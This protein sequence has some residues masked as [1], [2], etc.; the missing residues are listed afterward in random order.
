MQA[1]GPVIVLCLV[2]LYLEFNSPAVGADYQANVYNRLQM[3]EAENRSLSRSQTQLQSQLIQLQSIQ[4][5]LPWPAW[6]KDRSGQV[7]Y[8]NPAY[9]SW[10]LKPRGYTL[11]DYVGKDD[12]AVWPEDVA[13]LYAAHDQQVL[14]ESRVLIF[15]EPVPQADGTLKRYRFIK[16]PQRVGNSIVGVAGM[17]IPETNPVEGED[18]LDDG[19]RDAGGVVDSLPPWDRTLVRAAMRAPIPDWDWA[20]RGSPS[21]DT[22]LHILLWRR[23]YDDD[24]VHGLAAHARGLFDGSRGGRR[25]PW[26]YHPV[27]DTQP[28]YAGKPAGAGRPDGGAESAREGSAGG[29]TWPD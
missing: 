16:Y 7:V 5:S 9:E 22:A 17:V 18:G 8:A 4:D 21:F 1:L 14:R 11:F 13:R 10:Y 27:R 23:A 15:I 3:L 19:S 24:G 29:L 25:N 6:L 28:S 26:V 20:S 12:F 2:L